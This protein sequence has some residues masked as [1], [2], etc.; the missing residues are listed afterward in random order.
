MRLVERMGQ[1][2][3]VQPVR[4]AHPVEVDGL[5]IL[6]DVTLEYFV[7]DEVEGLEM[8]RQVLLMDHDGVVPTSDPHVGLL[9]ELT[10]TRT[11][12]V[13]VGLEIPVFRSTDELG[14]HLAPALEARMERL[15]V[16]DH[17]LELAA[18]ATIDD[19]PGIPVGHKASSDEM[20]E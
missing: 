12:D 15:G 7:R 17:E 19:A 14:L 5:L 6:A 16:D 2:V 10:V 8:P 11:D 18:V 13:L 4:G 9:E 20:I 3:S 1:G